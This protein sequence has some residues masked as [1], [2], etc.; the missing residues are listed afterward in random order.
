MC[1][2]WVWLA[3][4]DAMKSSLVINPSRWHEETKVSVLCPPVTLQYRTFI[5][6]TLNY[7]FPS[8]WWKHTQ[9][10]TKLGSNYI[11]SFTFKAQLITLFYIKIIV[12]TKCGKNSQLMLHF[13][14]WLSPSATSLFQFGLLAQSVE[15]SSCSEQLF[16]WCD[17]D[18]QHQMWLVKS[19]HSLLSS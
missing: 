4:Q 14:D 13:V 6:T 1:L 9:Q 17:E 7:D 18:A 19:G 8:S 2:T 12:V 15:F 3:L 10:N 11:D 16:L 5:V